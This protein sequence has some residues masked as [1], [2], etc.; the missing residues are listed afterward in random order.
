MSPQFYI[1]TMAYLKCFISSFSSLFLFPKTT[2]PL[3]WLFSFRK[4]QKSLSDEFALQMFVYPNE[5][6][7]FSPHPHSSP[8]CVTPLCP[9]S[10][11]PYSKKFSKN[12]FFIISNRVKILSGEWAK[13]K[14]RVAVNKLS[15]TNERVVATWN[16]KKWC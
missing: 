1:L 10:Y 13:I 4:N 14:L 5:V 15:A 2:P 8:V 16:I 7:Y 12:F 11:A 6:F 3:Y 9:C